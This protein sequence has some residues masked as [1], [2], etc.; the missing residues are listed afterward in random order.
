M[1]E[2]G[3]ERTLT[4]NTI[5]IHAGLYWLTHLV[6]SESSPVPSSAAAWCSVAATNC[7]LV[8]AYRVDHKTT[9]RERERERDYN[10]AQA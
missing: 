1:V 6:L 10:D 2:E 5:I 8:D 4:P 3:R 9:E 7:W